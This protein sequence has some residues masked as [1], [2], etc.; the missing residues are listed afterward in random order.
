M[1]HVGNIKERIASFFYDCTLLIHVS[2]KSSHSIGCSLK[3]CLVI[4]PSNHPISKIIE[5][6]F[7]GTVCKT[8]KYDD[9]D[10]EMLLWYG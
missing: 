3:T 2:Y 1:K 7:F 6:I 8:P 10:G 5:K 9:D 4:S